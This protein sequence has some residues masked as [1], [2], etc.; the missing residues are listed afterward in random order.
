MQLITKI[1][2]VVPTKGQKDSDK[3]SNC[4][5][6]SAETLDL[7]TLPG[8]EDDDEDDEDYEPPVK[9]R[10]KRKAA[11]LIE[12]DKDDDEQDTGDGDGEQ[13]N[14]DDDED[15]DN[16]DD[17]DEDYEQ[18]DEDEDNDDEEDDEEITLQTGKA[19]QRKWK[20]LVVVARSRDMHMDVVM[21]ERRTVRQHCTNVEEATEFRKYIR[22]VMKTFNENV[23]QGKQVKKYLLEMIE[24]VREAC[25]NMR[26]PGMDFS[27][28]EIVRTFSDPS[29]KAWQAKLSGVEYADR[30]DLKEA[31]TKHNVNIVTSDRSNKD[32]GQVA[33]ATLDSLPTAQKNDCTQMLKRLIKYNKE[34]HEST[35][36]VGRELMGLLDYFPISSWLQ[37]ADA[38]TR[39]LVYV[40]VPEVVEIVKRAQD[41]INKKKPKEGK[42]QI[43]EIVEEQ[44]LPDM[45][46]LRHVWGYS[47]DDVGKKTVSAIIYKYLKEQMFPKEHVTTAFLSH[48]FTT[49]S[50]TLHKY[51]V[52]MKYKGG[53]PPGKYRQ[54]E[55]E[56]WTR[57][58]T[59]DDVNR[60]A[61]SSG[62]MSQEKVEGKGTGKKSGKKRDAAE[63]R[64][65]TSKP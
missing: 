20:K 29:F 3:P 25:L 60:G 14:G 58:Q 21:E 9:S 35:T 50:S 19:E 46:L 22:D 27:P 30:N 5:K 10:R 53:A 44:N 52:R 57:K 61:S 24:N 59:Q 13:D 11:L 28:E 42:S 65:D 49:T 32:A 51:I 54:D 18:D 48:K 40:Q 39:P 2:V 41:M 63:I 31:N 62:V 34:A 36:K 6:L 1:G 33:R 16:G 17:N 7:F 12:D 38:T 43:D 4:K 64:D 26:Y 23:R 45:M 47:K 15:Q 56:E 55:S 8:F 37:V